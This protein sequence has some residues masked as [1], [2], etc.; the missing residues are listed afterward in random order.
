VVEKSR[1]SKSYRRNR[2]ETRSQKAQ[3]SVEE[4]AVKFHLFAPSGREIWTVVG[5]DCD[6]IVHYNSSNSKRSFCSCDDYHFRVLGGSISEC[7][8]LMAVK[9]AI[10]Q[11]RFSKIVF[12]DDEYEGFLRALLT[13]IFSH[14]S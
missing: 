12:H 1:L 13:D 3:T 2:G 10:E 8:H 5:A 7:Y 4:L 11:T 14:I 6:F 9:K